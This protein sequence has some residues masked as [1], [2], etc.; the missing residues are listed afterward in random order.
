MNSGIHV[1]VKSVLFTFSWIF[2][3]PSWNFVF[4]SP[5]PQLIIYLLNRK[6]KERISGWH[7]KYRQV[8]E[9]PLRTSGRE[10][11]SQHKSCLSWFYPSLPQIPLLS[12]MLTLGSSSRAVH[13]SDQDRRGPTYLACS[14][15][16]GCYPG[17]SE[18][19]A[20]VVSGLVMCPKQG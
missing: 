12:F 2:F 16:H 10:Y 9:R 11:W 1:N 14:F 8:E 3:F 19:L 6:Q 15:S 4:S 18:H 20:I 7:K 13:C 17:L 5:G